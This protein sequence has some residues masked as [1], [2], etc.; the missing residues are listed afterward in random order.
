MCT[1]NSLTVGC[2]HSTTI[3]TECGHEPNKWKKVIYTV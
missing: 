2:V 1:L 3:V